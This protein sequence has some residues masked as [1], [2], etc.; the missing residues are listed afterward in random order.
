MPT[1]AHS[2]YFSAGEW[3]LGDVRCLAHHAGDI[4]AAPAAADQT[5]IHPLI[6]AEHA[7]GNKCCGGGT[8]DE[9]TSLHVQ[10]LAV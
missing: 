5:D 3:E 6:G 1:P 7:V 9:L 8:F 10:A 2:E 4:P